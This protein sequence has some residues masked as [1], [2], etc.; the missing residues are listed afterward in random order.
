M[1]KKK[2]NQSII[3]RI[4]HSNVSLVIFSLFLAVVVW[5]IVKL[6]FSES[7]TRVLTNLKVNLDTSIAEKNDYYAFCSDDELNVNVEISGK[8]YDMNS[9]S[10]SVSDIVLNA[11][12]GAVDT[13]GY[14]TI[15]VNAISNNP[16]I[17]ITS[18]NPSTINVFF[19]RKNQ[20]TVDVVANLVNKSTDLVE[21]GYVVGKPAPSVATVEVEG[22]AT[23][24]ENL[25]KVVFNAEIKEKDLPLKATTDVEATVNFDMNSEKGKDYLKCIGIGDEAAPAIITVPVSL[26]KTVPVN[27]NF[28][29]QPE[30]YIDNPPEVKIHPSSV[31]ISCSSENDIESLTIGTIDFSKLGNSKKYFSFAVEDSTVYTLISKVEEFSVSVDLS[32][33]KSKTVEVTPN[34]VF[35]GKKDDCSYSVAGDEPLSITVCGPEDSIKNIE[36]ENIQLEIN[37]SELN[38]N[39]STPQKVKISKVSFDDDKCWAKGD[40][41]CDVIV[42]K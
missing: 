8:S 16:N 14:R 7:T 42:K 4:Y 35:T 39:I 10:F 25:N 9:S 37:V 30:Y 1:K 18:V 41:Y 11:A 40:Y 23:A 32:D 12:P 38:H 5:S 24:I 29:N 27:V 20:K 15:T 36:A 26:V 28:I 6:N 19:D 34:P 3:S 21:S 22:P 17:T 13:S 31:E 2:E 33:K